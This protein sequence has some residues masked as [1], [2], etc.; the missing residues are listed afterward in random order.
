MYDHE[1]PARP[2]RRPRAPTSGSRRVRVVVAVAAALLAVGA[3]ALIWFGAKGST[4]PPLPP[5]TV[6]AAVRPGVPPSP[7]RGALVLAGQDRDLAVAI[8]ARHTGPDVDVQT[9]VLAP[10]G[11]G[12]RGLH[13][14]LRLL[15]GGRARPAPACGP[16]C[17]AAIV[18]P[19]HVV[20]GLE[21]HITGPGRRPS[22]VTFALP[23][24]WPV[25]ASGLVRRASATFRGL[26][27]L[28]YR[29]SLSSGP[30]TGIVTLWREEAPDRLS[31]HINTGTAGI[32][33]GGRRWDRSKGAP[34]QASTQDPILPMPVVPWGTS[35][36]D[37]SLLGSGTLNG[38]PVWRISMV[39]P[40]TPAWYTMTVEQST[41][42]TLR[43]DMIAAAHF[44]HH[45]YLRFN[46][47]IRIVPP[48]R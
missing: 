37:A 43:L 34:W 48:A 41:G 31:Y 4:A 13:V 36:E 18:S 39:D 46:P 16:G 8:A 35:W 26:R 44:M 38:K 40:V 32:V 12:Q 5:P 9:T 23:K 7:P 10:T 20:Q 33:I 11:D 15:P 28:V 2:P 22:T 25:P 47:P 21:V 27:T 24:R 3:S 1:A 42:R 17:Y 29:E 19:G 45:R 30:S 14:A 6:A